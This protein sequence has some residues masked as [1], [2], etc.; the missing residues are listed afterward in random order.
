MDWIFGVHAVQSL[1][2]SSPE[3]VLELLVQSGRR[4]DR[5]E[6]IRRLAILHGVTVQRASL[7]NMSAKVSGRHQGVIARCAE[8]PTHD[9]HFLYALARSSARQ[10]FFLM[11]D[12]VTDPHNLGACLRSAACAGV[13]AVI[14]P[15]DNSVGLT[16]TVQKVASGAAEVTPLIVVTSLART[17]VKLQELGIWVVCSR[18]DRRCCNTSCDKGIEW[19]RLC[20]THL[21]Q[22]SFHG[23][24]KYSGRRRLDYIYPVITTQGRLRKLK[25]LHRLVLVLQTPLQ[26]RPID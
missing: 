18:G 7:K 14:V 23:G 21:L 13:D 12:G 4:D 26:F 1:L 8:G 3:R 2:K 10:G 6:K 25:G 22:G 19:H 24:D 15:K 17:L 9:E 16:P 20:Y 5:L 11:L